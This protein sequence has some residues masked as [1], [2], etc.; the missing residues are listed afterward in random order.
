MN[1]QNVPNEKQW[2]NVFTIDYYLFEVLSQKK[3]SCFSWKGILDWNLLQLVT[4]IYL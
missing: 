3:N 1:V 4:K 2:A